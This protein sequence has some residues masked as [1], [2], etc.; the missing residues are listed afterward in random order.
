MAQRTRPEIGPGDI[1]GLKY[2]TV[3]ESL[4]GRLAGAGTQRDRAGNRTLFMDRYC[5]LVLLHFF[6][7][8]V[9]SLRGLQQASALAKVKKLLGSSRHSLGSLSEASRV[10]DA[11]LLTGVIAELAGR[12][13]PLLDGPDADALAGLTAVDGSLLPALPRMAWALWL[14]DGHRAAK[15]HLHFD[16]LRGVPVRATVT[17]GNGCERA[18]LRRTLQAGRLYVVDRGYVEYR[19][20]RDILDA[21]SSFV[22]RLQDN[23]VFQA[24]QA[25][26]PRPLSPEAREAGVVR[27]VVVSKLG[28]GEDALKVP[29]RVV[30]VELAGKTRADGSP[31]TLL[32]VTDRLELDAELVA[33][34]YKHRWSIEL[35]FRWFKCVLGCRHLLSECENGVRLQVYLG[36]IAS[37]MIVLWTN[38]K[39]TRRTWEMV[40]FLL[41][42]WATEEELAAHVE[43]L[44]KADA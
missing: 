1:G 20:Y 28:V 23:A 9:T 17:E 2:F 21:G 36:L 10:F 31:D 35:F 22:A 25:A 43:G 15:L 13:V 42:G 11:E 41:Q 29:V 33:L 40:Q 34:A 7:P 27:D 14:D 38:R 3:L 26:P 16:V 6:N 37:L 30:E 44:K 18:Q 5:L 19:F 12:A 32:L 8:V 24:D 39:P 4:L